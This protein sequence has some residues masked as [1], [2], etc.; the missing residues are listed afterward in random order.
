[1]I[2][3]FAPIRQRGFEDL[4]TLIPKDISG[5]PSDLDFCRQSTSSKR[6]LSRVRRKLPNALKSDEHHIIRAYSGAVD[7]KAKSITTDGLNDQST[8]IA[9]CPEV[10][11]MGVHIENIVQAFQWKIDSNIGVDTITQRL[12]SGG[13]DF[14]LSV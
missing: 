5:H 9:V 3:F 11:G 7:S 2:L 8:R 6:N 12:G 13:R 1:L 4:S 10:L 14:G